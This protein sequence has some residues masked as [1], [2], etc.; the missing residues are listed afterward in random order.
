MKLFNRD[1]WDRRRQR[2]KG[3]K[4]RHTEDKIEKSNSIDGKKGCKYDL[5]EIT[6]KLFQFGQKHK[7]APYDTAER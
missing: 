7:N 6:P 3:A 2:R 1:P 4:E 5:C